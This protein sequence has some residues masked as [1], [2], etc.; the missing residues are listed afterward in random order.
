MSVLSSFARRWGA[1]IVFA[2]L[3]LALA[4]A[5]GC[6]SDAANDA[7]SG[8][9]GTTSGGTLPDQAFELLTPLDGEVVK[10]G[11]SV[12]VVVRAPSGLS[13]T[14][15]VGGE[16][17]DAAWSADPGDPALV[18]A[19]YT[20]ASDAAGPLRFVVVGS[21]SN[22][23][24]AFATVTVLQPIESVSQMIGPDETVVAL[25]SGAKL[26]IPKGAVSGGS[27]SFE[28]YPA[29][30]VPAFAKS[31]TLSPLYRVHLSVDLDGI[32]K[33]LF[34]EHPASAAQVAAGQGGSG[35]VTLDAYEGDDP[36]V[37]DRPMSSRAEL[38]MNPDGTG[39]YR[40][41]LSP[42][43]FHHTGSSSTLVGLRKHPYPFDYTAVEICTSNDDDQGG[44]TPAPTCKPLAK[45]QKPTLPLSNAGDGS[46]AHVNVT[47]TVSWLDK[48]PSL[49]APGVNNLATPYPT[50][51][52]NPLRELYI[53]G[54][55]G[56]PTH[57]RPHEGNDLRVG[58][59]MPNNRDPTIV[60]AVAAGWATVQMGG[61]FHVDINL[62]GPNGPKFMVRYLHLSKFLGFTADLTEGQVIGT[63]ASTKLVC[64]PPKKKG[65]KPDCQPPD[66]VAPATARYGLSCSQVGKKMLCSLV[67]DDNNAPAS[68]TEPLADHA[69]GTDDAIYC[70]AQMPRGVFFRD[71]NPGDVVGVS[72]STK[73]GSPHL[74]LEMAYGDFSDKDE[75]FESGTPIDLALAY[76]AIAADKSVNDGD[77]PVR[78][79]SPALRFAAELDPG[80]GSA[81][82]GGFSGALLGIEASTLEKSDKGGVC[83]Y[84]GKAI[85]SKQ[86]AL[87]KVGGPND[88]GG[89]TSL[90][91]DLG[92]C[93]YQ[94][95]CGKSTDT[96]VAFGT[97][98]WRWDNN[99]TR[100]WNLLS[101]LPQP[102]S[103]KK[104]A[105]AG[106]LEPP[107]GVIGHG[108]WDARPAIITCCDASVD[109]SCVTM[110]KPPVPADFEGMTVTVKATNEFADATMTLTGVTLVGKPALYMGT[111]M[112]PEA[113][114]P[115]PISTTLPPEA[116]V[117]Q[118]QDK[119][120][121]ACV[122]G[123]PP[124]F[125]GKDTA[126][127]CG[128]SNLVGVWKD[129]VSKKWQWVWNV[130]GGSYTTGGGFP[131]WHEYQFVYDSRITMGSKTRYDVFLGANAMPAGWNW[132]RTLDTVVTVKR[133]KTTYVLPD[134][135]TM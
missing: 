10:P 121:P 93:V 4:H 60:K 18:H 77:M 44:G 54:D 105:K 104:E 122:A 135:T 47:A 39:R 29:S 97:T 62:T 36:D 133:K 37:E 31:K 98:T 2:S 63:S 15:L 13:P 59:G 22:A 49:G 100:R 48:P 46:K 38:T 114:H 112:G 99:D 111:S 61:Q 19:P 55:G 56:G 74:H 134:S 87:T 95:V 117:F 118:F 130:S 28:S 85:D 119:N 96:T 106:Y 50:S 57:F 20:I 65:K 78:S 103:D 43:A 73:T 9:G 128:R 84:D 81:G 17:I 120:Q 131:Q 110:E 45:D 75:V 64:T 3:G 32:A 27:V 68:L 41:E 24:A 91:W 94:E 124:L 129:K 79:Q 92:P 14:L 90:A 7:A 51:P 33:S 52:F 86:Y 67:A 8:P 126:N 107:L 66:V 11:D 88:K 35:P 70:L 102:S 109:P 25:P 101:V 34:L 42:D 76:D 108:V 116:V 5:Q 23:L 1:V 72:G 53:D 40:A 58:N 80:D 12:D 71:V 82:G 115:L 26:V 30:G 21:G 132:I 6:S 89:T 113:G 69:C 83:P 16:P 125:N 127:R 123:F